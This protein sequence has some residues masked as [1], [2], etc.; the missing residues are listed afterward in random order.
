MDAHENG[1]GLA[2]TNLGRNERVESATNLGRNERAELAMNL[3]R[4]E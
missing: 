3:G 4:N 1:G 2:A